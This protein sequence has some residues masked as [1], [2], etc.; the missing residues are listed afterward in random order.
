MIQEQDIE[1]AKR[2]IAD[3]PSLAAF[4]LVTLQDQVNQ[5]RTTMDAIRCL[6]QNLDIAR[7]GDLDAIGFALGRNLKPD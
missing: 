4:R 5:L 7:Q 1:A 3:T 2:L 6:S